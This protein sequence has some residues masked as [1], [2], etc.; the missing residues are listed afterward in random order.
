MWHCTATRRGRHYDSTHIEKWHIEERGWSRVGYAGLVLLNGAFDFLIPYDKDDVI[1]S[2][3]ISN[4]AKGWNGRTK[5]LCYVG[6]LDSYG[7]P[8]DTRT[9][10]QYKVM[11]AITKFH[12]MLWPDIKLIGHNQVSKKAC[13]SF[14]VPEWCDQIGLLDKNIDRRNYVV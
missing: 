3:E 10:H 11:A 6:G 1:E 13:P 5:H 9:T 2:W 4:G 8:M 14:N 7:Q 12:A